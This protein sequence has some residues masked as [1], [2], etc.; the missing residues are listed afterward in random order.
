MK[1]IY[2]FKYLSSCLFV[3]KLLSLSSLFYFSWISSSNSKRPRPAPSPPETIGGGSRGECL[4]VPLVPDNL[5][6]LNTISATP[7]YR[8]YAIGFIDETTLTQS[9]KSLKYKV[10]I[11][12]SDLANY[13][14]FYDSDLLTKDK[15]VKLMGFKIPVKMSS[16]S[17]FSN[18]LELNQPY[19]ITRRCVLEGNSIG[20]G[21]EITINRVPNTYESTNL[22][23]RQ[24]FDLFRR[25][26]LELD[27]TNL[28]F[29]QEA[30][31]NSK[32][33]A[34]LFREVINKNI[35]LLVTEEPKRN[36]YIEQAVNEFKANLTQICK[37]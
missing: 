3:V 21:V 36:N 34:I 24:K 30:C 26:N 32:D 29:S 14:N 19:Q 35:A 20:S 22:T 10:S 16:L 27:A 31:S 8:V 5:G 25:S 2:R 15:S 9:N 23:L 7:Y 11:E 4:L 17:N 12:Y 1:F 33:A 18:G 6:T 28:L 13:K 37:Q